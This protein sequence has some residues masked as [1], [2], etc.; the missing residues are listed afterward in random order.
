MPGHLDEQRVLERLDSAKDA[1]GLHQMNL[2]RLLLGF[3]TGRD[4]PF[5]CTPH[6]ILQ[7]LV[8]HNIPLSGA[9]IVVVGR[10]ITVGRYLG[11]LLTLHGID[12]T[13]TVTHSKTR[14]LNEHLRRAD[15]IISAAGVPGIIRAECVKRGAVVV[16]VGVTRQWDQLAGKNRI[17][18]DVAQGVDQVAAWVSPNPGG[19]GPMTRAMLL[20]NV[21]DAAERLG[22]A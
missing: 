4:F 15:I 19:V 8:R 6:G 18:G 12:A 17:F 22:V 9:D 13:V 11:P 20:Q 16:D 10:G 3:G 21:V 5:P 2:G 14:D 1:D 7:L